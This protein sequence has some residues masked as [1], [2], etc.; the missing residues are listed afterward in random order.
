MLPLTLII[1]A[2]YLLGS[3]PFGYLVARWKGVDILHQGSGNIGAT[4]V[5][6][7][8]GRRLGILVFVLDVA[9]GA[10]PVAT[11]MWTTRRVELELP[12]NTLEVSAGL[13][14]FL[15][16]LFPVYLGFR[17]GKG[18][19]TGAGIVL[20]L[21]PLP[22]LAALLT[23]LVVVCLSRYVSLASLTGAVTLCVVRLVTTSESF[24]PDNRIL[25]WFCLV[26]AGL[27]ILR[28]RANIGR[29]LRG[30]ENYLKDSPTMELLIKTIHVLALGLWFGSAVFFSFVVTPVIFDTFRSLPAKEPPERPAWLPG[31]FNQEQ[32]NQLAGLAVGPIFPWYFLLEG[33]CGVL[34][35]STAVSWAKS[36]PRRTVHQLRF[37]IL[38]LAL[39][40]VLAGWPIA[41]HV[42]DFRKDRYSEDATVA[43][44][45]AWSFTTWHV[46]SLG[47]NLVTIGLVFLAM[48]LAAK[49]PECHSCAMDEKREDRT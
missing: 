43:A 26:A 25:T 47:L 45:A 44:N 24:G 42:A 14:A 36:V 49:L 20:V 4:N 12:K 15:G 39:A 2:S 46:Y 40:T 33:V 1:L 35:L 23:W 8:L 31:T 32:G 21:L 7:V 48:A 34:A 17:G 37:L 6:R 11:A 3:I 9:K 30:N 18:V 5:G 22:A 29:L 41:E 16:H 28:H 10:I 19:A 38:A 13:A 27:V